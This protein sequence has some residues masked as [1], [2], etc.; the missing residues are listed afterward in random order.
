[1][2]EG[3]SLE[4]SMKLMTYLIINNREII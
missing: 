3:L 2:M 1:V 4:L